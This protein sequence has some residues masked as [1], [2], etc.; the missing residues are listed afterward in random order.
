MPSAVE[1]VARYYV[2]S[3]YLQQH[4]TTWITFTC[5]SQHKQLMLSRQPA[6]SSR[7]SSELCRRSRCSSARCT[8]RVP[9]RCTR[10]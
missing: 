9:R 2:D 6:L 3:F 1:R 7:G 4:I 5:S 8:R 10:T